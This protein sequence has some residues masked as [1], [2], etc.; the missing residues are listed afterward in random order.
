MDMS[1]IIKQFM[2][3][4]THAELLVTNMKIWANALDF[5]LALS[6]PILEDAKVVYWM[7]Q[8]L[9]EKL[10]HLLDPRSKALYLAVA[11]KHPTYSSAAMYEYTFPVAFCVAAG[12]SSIYRGEATI[13]ARKACIAEPLDDYA[14]QLNIP[15]DKFT[16]IIHDAYP[17]YKAAFMA[18]HQAIL[19]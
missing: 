6:E 2:G 18:H 11:L 13:W 3:D 4:D 19:A 5:E 1:N 9:K 7:K 8:M 14:E 17:L 12:M 16:E 10:L 15:D